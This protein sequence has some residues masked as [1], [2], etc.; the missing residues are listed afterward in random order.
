MGE[1]LDLSGLQHMMRAGKEKGQEKNQKKKI[2]TSS[3]NSS[4]SKN[5]T[6]NRKR[7]ERKPNWNYGGYVG[8][9][10]NFVPISDK[11]YDYTRNGKEEKYHNALEKE[12]LSGYITYQIEAKTPII[13]DSGKTNDECNEGEF[14]KDAYGKYAIPGSSIRGLVRNNAQ[15][16]SFSDISDDIEDYNLMYRN[17]AAGLNKYLY[18]KI[19]GEDSLP[20][21][22]NTKVL[23]NV[24]A[25]YIAK[26]G[27]EYIIYQTKVDKIGTS[28]G[29]MNYYVASERKILEEYQR[30]NNK[31]KFQYLFSSELIMQY[32]KN[33]KFIKE[34][35]KYA[36]EKK[37]MFNGRQDG[38]YKPYYIEISYEI[39]GGHRVD[40]IGE[41]GK[42]SKKGY[43]LSSGAMGMKKAI[44]IVPEIDKEKDYIC[45]PEKDVDSYRRDFESKKNQIKGKEK[46]FG[47]PQEDEVKPVFYTEYGGRLCFGFT[48]RFRLFYAKSVKEGFWQKATK[49]D[50]CKALFGYAK[51]ENSYKSRLSF[52]DASTENGQVL[53]MREL[54]LVTPK[55]T[56]CLDYIENT[57]GSDNVV[58]Y[59]DEFRLRGIKQYWLKEEAEDA[60]EIKN[61]NVGSKLK[62][63][64]AGTVFHGKIRFH[65]LTKDELGLLFWSL[66]L[67]KESE[68]N[69]GKAKA[70]GYGR[71]KIS[72]DNVEIF[73][74]E[75]AYDLDKFSLRPF[76]SIE[77]REKE[78]YIDCFKAEIRKWLGKEPEE[79]E[80][81]RSFLLMKDSTRI[82]DKSK[83]KYMSIE[84]KNN[85]GEEV[86]EYQN[87]VREK[88]PLPKIDKVIKK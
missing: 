83:T 80:S 61:E 35:N 42:Y 44:Y 69:I 39:Y 48:P 67:N 65:N 16:L 12:L 9:P 46:F 29:E 24:K 74:T 43:L 60:V 17:V 11:T 64:C 58:T 22:K 72:I 5:N 70:Y 66:E 20:F 31:S 14:Y 84:R 79:H 2:T 37:W 55:P 62:P 82:P 59:N 25:G 51:K 63:L 18:N 88:Y 76:Y 47:L 68:Q 23:K 75:E 71:V 13:I 77:Q 36:V 8:A 81:I 50:Y 45:I 34:K 4:Y 3:Q 73:K 57:D 1:E 87:R 7:E 41:V 28:Y 19:L 86:R 78:D 52:Q 56:S 32:T 40:A 53:E 15:I 30:D 38:P 10:Y 26:K 33:C 54:I 85:D 6:Q 49:M 21:E 27:K